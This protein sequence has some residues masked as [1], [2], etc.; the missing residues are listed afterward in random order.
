VN[1][2]IVAADPAALLVMSIEALPSVPSPTLPKW[3][4]EGLAET[5]AKVVV[6]PPTKNA[7]IAKNL[8]KDAVFAIVPPL[9][10]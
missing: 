8:T 9:D 6:A 4:E 3:I 5:C 2:V 7:M 10:R 1:P